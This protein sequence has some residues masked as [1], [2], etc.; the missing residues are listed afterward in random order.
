MKLLCITFS[1]LY[2]HSCIFVYL[3]AEYLELVLPD[4]YIITSQQFSDIESD[5]DD[6]YYN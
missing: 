5:D 2:Y 1:I 6:G 4:Y 3:W